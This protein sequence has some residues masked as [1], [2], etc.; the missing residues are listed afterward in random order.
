M[1]YPVK[2]SAKVAESARSTS[3]SMSE[4]QNWLSLQPGRLLRAAVGDRLA[5][6]QAEPQGKGGEIAEGHLAVIVHVATLEVV[7]GAIASRANQAIAQ[8]KG[9][10]VIQVHR[11]AAAKGYWRMLELW[12]ARFLSKQR[13]GARG[14]LSGYGR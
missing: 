3:P 8:G 14:K 1:S 6:F 12:S 7:L 9:R 2:F 11:P 5:G 4:L 10:E 13:A